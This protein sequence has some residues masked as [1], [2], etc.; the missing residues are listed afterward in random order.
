MTDRAMNGIRRPHRWL[1]AGALVVGLLARVPGIYWGHNFPN[2]SGYGAHHPD[3]WT[4]VVLAEPLIAP[5]AGAR[6]NPTYPKGLAVM[7][8]VPMIAAR[9]VTGKFRG[10]RPLVRWTTAVGRGISVLFGVGTVLVVFLLG[11]RITGDPRVGLA[12]AWF[13]G[14][15]GLHVTQSHFFVADVP[16]LFFTLLGL[17]LLIV[18]L[19]CQ[20]DG[21]H[22]AL[23][24]AAL[25]FGVAFGIKLFVAGLPSL[26][27]VTVLRRE[28][29]RRIAHAA[30]F[31][32]AGFV[33]INLGMFGPLDLLAAI[34]SGVN[35][36]YQYS[37]AMGLV[38]YLLESPAVFGLP[39][40]VGAVVGTAMALRRLTGS[41]DKRL[42]GIVAVLGLPLLVHAWHVTFSLDLFPRHLVVFIP[43]AAL[44]AGY[45]LVRALEALRSRGIRPALLTVPVFAWLALFVFDGERGFVSDTRNDAYRW[46]DANVAEGTNIWWYYHDLGRYPQMR[47]PRDGRAPYLVF[48]MMQANHILSGVGLRDSYPRDFR[49]V[50]DVSSQEEVDAVQAVFR[51]DSEYREVARFREGYFMPEYLWSDRWLGNRSRNYLTEIVVFKRD[52]AP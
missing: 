52:T 46:L 47:F 49:N 1:L 36:P 16:A 8:A 7:T 50:F 25:A 31:F 23:R 28:R 11:R 42:L 5:S 24:W 2:P 15:G 13:L 12:A 44:T 38:V 43:F 30:V 40:L 51:G 26:A 18:D 21:G 33:A 39:F 4:H 35:D 41:R 34:R 10:P 9:A 29:I 32:V 6:W 27:L 45:A 14:L 17:L 20:E 22:E 3:E 48:E 37:R 19:D